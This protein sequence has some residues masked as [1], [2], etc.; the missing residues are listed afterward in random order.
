MRD[1]VGNLI[2]EDLLTGRKK[3]KKE[4]KREVLAENRQNGKS[5][6]DTYRLIAMANG[7]ELE[8]APR[9]R[10]FISRKRNPFTG[11]VRITHVEVKSSSTAPLSK[12]QKK[13]KKK[14]TNYKVV[15]VNPLI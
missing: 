11:K 1:W 14:R 4:L 7:E 9:G 5:G 12:L 15:R 13:T 6:E 2:K 10:D 3:S 8:R